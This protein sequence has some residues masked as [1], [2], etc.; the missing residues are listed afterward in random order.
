QG[1]ATGV[2]SY[3]VSLGGEW[4]TATELAACPIGSAYCCAQLAGGASPGETVSTLWLGI[5]VGV[6]PPVF[7]VL[8]YLANYCGM[9]RGACSVFDA[10]VGLLST[11]SL[12]TVAT[13]VIKSLVGRPRPNYFALLEVEARSHFRTFSTAAF[14]R[15]KSFPS[16]HSSTSMASMAFIS[17]LL[18]ADIATSPCLNKPSQRARF[19]RTAAIYA[20][21]LPVAL[22][23]WVGITR[24]QNYWHNQ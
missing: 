9:Y 13:V 3:P 20:S 12:V 11:T 19:H 6:L 1:N 22:S 17:F 7:I 16:G 10:F 4:C 15:I 2:N 24:I 21:L 8:R 14:R 23:V 5:I 18:L